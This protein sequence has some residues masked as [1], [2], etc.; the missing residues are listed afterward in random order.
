ML[1]PKLRTIVWD[2]DNHDD[3][4]DNDDD[5]L[6]LPALVHHSQTNILVLAHKRFITDTWTLSKVTKDD[7]VATENL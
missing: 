3:D 5:L 4:D 2:A 7:D 6:K 1:R